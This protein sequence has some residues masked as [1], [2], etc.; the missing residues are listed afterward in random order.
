MGAVAIGW[1]Y[2]QETSANFAEEVD[3]GAYHCGAAAESAKKAPHCAK[4]QLC[5]CWDLGAFS[6]SA[7][8]VDSKS[9]AYDV[10]AYWGHHY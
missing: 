1:H 6:G 10:H 2:I 8:E 3:I 9:D 4:A 5:L 7:Q